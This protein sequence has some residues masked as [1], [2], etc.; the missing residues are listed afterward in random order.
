MSEGGILALYVRFYGRFDDRQGADAALARPGVRPRKR[1]AD[2][3][4]VS[5]RG[6]K[7]G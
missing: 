6:V 5:V 4:Q 3:L 2:V 7:I 1:P